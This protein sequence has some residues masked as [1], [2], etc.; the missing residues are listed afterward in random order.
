MPMVMIT[1]QKPVK[2][3]KQGQFRIVNV[4]DMMQPLTKFTK[5]VESG[6]RIPSSVRE[7]FRKAQEERPGATH[8]ELPEDIACEA[9]DV[10]VVEPSFL[11]AGPWPKRRRFGEPRN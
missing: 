8:L 4:V 1:G 9:V 3:S 11:L 5:R 10:P 6:N 2:T 7:A